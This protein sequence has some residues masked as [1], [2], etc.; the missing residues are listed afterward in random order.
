MSEHDVTFGAMGCAVR[1]IIGAEAGGPDPAAAA[2]ESRAWLADFDA[3]LSRFRPD[4]E[5]CS[6]NADQRESVPA[7]ALLRA[8]VAAGVW[9][10]HQTGGLV[11][12][13][14]VDQI[15]RA[16]YVGS[17]DAGGVDSQSLAEAFRSAPP[18]RPASPSS[19]A[20]WRQIQVDD[21]A[22]TISRPPG[23]RF[24]TGGAGKGLAADALA[25]RLAAHSR[26]MIDCGGDV[27]V[28]GQDVGKRPIA[29]EIEHPLTGSALH[30]FA[31]GGGAV[32]TSGI[33]RR[34][35]RTREG[36]A[37]H[38]LDP[39]TGRPA[40]TG[41]IQA[42]ALAA[43]ALE[44]ETLAKAALLSGADE[45]RRILNRQGGAIVHDDGR[46]ELIGALDFEALA[47]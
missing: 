43:T 20:G 32:A 22:G 30:S 1:L 27:R 44:A 2:R 5:L 28:T 4:S 25:H 3:R 14:L 47:A 18:R 6:L 17:R 13:T 46:V 45:A 29:I 7:S 8:A 19:T 9:A 38:L 42:T 24:D 35:W 33:A 37:H 23:L 39:A 12:P 36:Y 21:A 34:I 15:E 10:A 41:L 40:W 11:D 31:L 16:G 26:V